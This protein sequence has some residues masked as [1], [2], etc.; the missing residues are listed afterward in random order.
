MDHL[1]VRGICFYCG[2]PEEGASEFCIEPC[3]KTIR[4]AV[5]G[6][7][8]LA[9]I[10][11]EWTHAELPPYQILETVG[12]RVAEAWKKLS[13]A[14]TL[15]VVR[16]TKRDGGEEIY[17]DFVLSDYAHVGESVQE[18]LEALGEGC[19]TLSV[20]VDRVN[21]PEILTYLC[22]WDLRK[23]MELRGPKTASATAKLVAEK[24]TYWRRYGRL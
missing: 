24:V 12:A 11:H 22:L 18:A 23:T 7:T 19:H 10:E 2:A 15:S 8:K 6:A 17:R 5:T 3:P 14:G 13:K 20:V 21:D 1:F 16:I 4:E 9:L